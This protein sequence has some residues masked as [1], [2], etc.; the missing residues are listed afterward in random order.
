MSPFKREQWRLDVGPERLTLSQAAC[1]H[2]VVA[3]SQ[4]VLAMGKQLEMGSA[5]AELF[6][7]LERRK[8][9]LHV[10]TD[11]RLARFF[12]VTPPANIYWL[13][14][15]K[16]ICA[17]RFESLFGHQATDWHIEA[18]WHA[19]DAFMACAL[20]RHL[21]EAVQLA[22]RHIKARIITLQPEFLMAWDAC[23]PATRPAQSWFVYES[24]SHAMVAES[25]KGRIRWMSHWLPTM[26][27]TPEAILACVAREA[28]KS[29][30]S[31]ASHIYLTGSDAPVWRH[32]GPHADRI[33]PL[34]H[35]PWKVQQASHGHDSATR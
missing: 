26:S 13:K 21:I 24:S 17:F 31:A 10:A 19:R 20:P 35:H 6:T 8:V 12:M 30:H 23:L 33:T 11:N 9:D 5:L 3:R 25:D 34:P 4:P 16:A 28:I 1:D 27:D 2:W 15:L 29:G 18:A 7:T 22:A 32:A 14:D